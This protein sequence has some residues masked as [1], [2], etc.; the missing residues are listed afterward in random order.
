MLNFV[1]VMIVDSDDWTWDLDS[2]FALLYEAEYHRRFHNGPGERGTNANLPWSF[3]GLTPYF[4]TDFPVPRPAERKWHELHTA[5][6]TSTT[7]SPPNRDA[8]ITFT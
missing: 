3:N 2:H 5:E 8:R 6:I 1:P 7:L 4:G